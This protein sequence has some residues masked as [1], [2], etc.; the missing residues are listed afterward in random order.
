MNDTINVTINRR[1]TSVVLANMLLNTGT[2]TMIG[3]ALSATANGVT[4]S[5]TTLNRISTKLSATPLITPKMRPTRAFAP[6][7][8]MA[9]QTLLQLSPSVDAID[10]GAGSRNG[11]MS[12]TRTMICQV[13]TNNTPTINGGTSTFQI[14]RRTLIDPPRRAHSCGR[15]LQRRAAPRAP[16]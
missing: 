11:W 6:V 5:F 2:S 12:N 13:P 7:T 16:R 10:D 8:S 1:G 3:I 14:E 4:S 9:S 15:F